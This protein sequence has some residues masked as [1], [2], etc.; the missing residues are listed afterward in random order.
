MR[1][2]KE[3]KKHKKKNLERECHNALYRDSI[4]L[5]WCFVLAFSKT[6]KQYLEHLS[7][8]YVEDVKC[9][10]MCDFLSLPKCSS[11]LVVTSRKLWPA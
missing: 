9:L 5:N 11:V 8:D 2:E 1:F 6:Q 10:S 7:K 4:I 3:P